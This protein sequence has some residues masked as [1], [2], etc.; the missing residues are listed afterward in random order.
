MSV[1]PVN[2]NIFY[3]AQCSM[4]QKNNYQLIPTVP[5]MSRMDNRV[6]VGF[7]GNSL[8][9]NLKI[10]QLKYKRPD[11]IARCNMPVSDWLQQ[12]D[13]Q[14]DKL[15]ALKILNKFEYISINGARDSFEKIHF[16]LLNTE[17]IDLNRTCFS[18]FGN[19]K[20]GGVMGYL[21]SQ[22]AEFREKGGNHPEKI[23]G[24][25]DKKFITYTELKTDSFVDNL[26]KR[27]FN[28]LV[29]VDDMIDNGNSFLEFATAPFRGNLKKFDKVYVVSLLEN[30]N[31]VNKIKADFPNINFIADKELKKFDDP[32]CSTFNE[33]EKR[34][35]KHFIDKYSK[36]IDS[37]EARKFE[38]SKV[39]VTFDWNTP[40]NT[41][42]PFCY[43]QKGCWQSLFKRYNGLINHQS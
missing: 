36:K 11:L 32:L 9:V 20:S 26:N 3:N 13:S 28:T 14:K 24:K 43:D 12:L 23:A 10:Q 39:F 34:E 30:K 41:P 8:L 1:I 19:A 25:I 7:A 21:Y 15:T 4:I 29:L 38:N 22:A 16:Q 17:C 6:S 35:I 31:G 40:G 27:G 5:V 42:M 37:W 2:A 18:F 33:K